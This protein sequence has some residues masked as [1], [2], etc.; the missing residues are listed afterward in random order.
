VDVNGLDINGV[1]ALHLAAE[2]GDL[3]S[4]RILI[5]YGALVNITDHQGENPL[6]YAVRAGHY[7]VIKALV[8][9]FKINMEMINED[10]ENVLDLCKAIG[11]P[12]LT[13]FIKILYNGRLIHHQNADII[14]NNSGYIRIS[15]H[16]CA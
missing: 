16:S 6:F 9:E 15:G 3:E 1:S 12:S 13:D 11:E 7:E 8:E 2:F 4:M 14:A 5:Q 10:D